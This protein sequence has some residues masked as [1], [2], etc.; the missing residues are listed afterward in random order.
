MKLKNIIYSV[1][2][3]TSSITFAQVPHDINVTSNGSAERVARF[4]VQ[5]ETRDFLEITNSTQHAGKFIPSIWGHQ[6]SDNRYVL[7]HFATTKSSLDNGTNPLMVFR[8]ELRNAINLNAP[9]G[10]TF[11]WGTTASNVV[12]RPVFAWENG[13]TQ[14][15]TI[16]A[17]G[18]IGI[19][20][21]TPQEKLHLNGSIRG[22]AAGGALRIRT[23]SG[24]LDVGVRNTNWAHIYTDRP[25]VIFNKPIYEIGGRFSSFNNSHLY[26]QTNGINRIFANRWNGRVGIGT[27]TPTSLLDINGTARIRS[28]TTNTSDSY[29]LTADNNG[30]VRRR[31]ISTIGGGSNNCGTN[32]FIL[33]NSSGSSVC[34]QI[35]DNGSRVGIGTSLPAYR[36]SVNGAVHSM[37]NLFISDRKFKKNIEDIDSPLETILKLNGEKY[38]WKVQKFDKYNF[39]DRKQIG[40]IAQEVKEVLPE[41]VHV[42]ENGEHSMNYTAVIPLL[43]EAIKEQQNQITLLQNKLDDNKVLLNGE[44][45]LLTDKTSFSTNYPNPFSTTTTVDYFIEKNIRN[46]KIVVYDTNGTAISSY[47]LDNRGTKSQLVINK[48]TLSTGIYFYTLITD[49]IVIGTKKMIVK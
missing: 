11:P 44:N 8:A 48:N 9:S 7:R 21:T 4:K 36:L 24:Y 15:M 19:G 26:L 32:N 33:K 10:G 16:R 14:L 30:N 5:D 28:L 37:S 13:N 12:N 25:R 40:F 23:G 22:N 1:I 29:V 46:A 45:L 17:N 38:N 47:R 6:E 43:V 27:T 2:F 34:S 39:T 41:I 42:D 49:D 35:Y 18:N 20:T 3:L 31:L